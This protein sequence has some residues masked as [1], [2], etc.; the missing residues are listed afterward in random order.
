MGIDV[1]IYFEA[2]GE[3][4]DLRI[5][6]DGKV[7]PANDY[8]RKFGPTH[9]ISSV[10]YEGDDCI[11]WPFSKCRGYGSLKYDGKIRKAHR[12]MCQLVHGDPPSARHEAAH[13][14][15]NHAC[16]NRNHIRWRTR[17]QNQRE[18]VDMGR[19]Y[20]LGRNGKLCR[21][22]AL[23]IRALKGTVSQDK[24]AAQFGIS[25]SNVAKIH[26]NEIWK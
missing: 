13:S 1:E 16:I 8:E 14:C 23:E 15:G 3:P 11:L 20:N 22:E 5:M 10:T 26:R 2:D 4:T 25:H 12:V 17:P 6:C 18:S 19:F 7:E 24:I 21:A 9:K